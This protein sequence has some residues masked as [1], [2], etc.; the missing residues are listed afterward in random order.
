MKRI[1]PFWAAT[2]VLLL[3]VGL[4]LAAVWRACHGH[5]AY[6]LDD[7]YIHLSIARNLLEDG[8]WGVSR[9]EYVPA[10]SSPLYV[11]LLACTGAWEFSPLLWNLAAG[12]AILRLG[13]RLL[14]EQ[15]LSYRWRLGLLLFVVFAAPLPPMICLG[16]EA[17]VQA[18]ITLAF[19]SA[20]GKEIAA[21][22]PL[23]SRFSLVLLAVLMC[24]IRYEGAFVVGIACLLL[25]L[26]LE[27]RKG[28]WGRA[29]LLGAAGAFPILLY[30]GISLWN[31]HHF[32]PNSIAI[33]GSVPATTSGA[34][35]HWIE[36]AM[37]RFYTSPFLLHTLLALFFVAWF[38]LRQ[39]KTCW[40]LS[41]TACMLIGCSL[42]VHILLSDVALYRYETY[43]LIAGILYAGA[44]IAPQVQD[45]WQ[46]TVAGRGVLLC[47]AGVLLLPFA[48]RTTFFTL[49]YPAGAR[50]IYEQQVQM[51]RFLRQYYPYASVA[52]N[53]IGA[54]TYF[55]HIRL[56]DMIGIGSTPIAE[57]AIAHGSIQVDVGVVR[58]QA[59]ARKVQI[60]L[61]YDNWVGDWVPSEW[62]RVGT[63]T[64]QDNFICAGET[65]S[66]YAVRPEEE[67][68]LRAHLAAFAPILPPGVVVKVE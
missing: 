45:F 2:C 64:I 57:N 20:I 50:N 42:V 22:K 37:D 65:V 29:I 51:G 15:G 5:L 19:V 24:S 25:I 12:I 55:T 59:A 26:P 11:L 54:I 38:G 68:A 60:A 33:K 34:V 67:A 43:L 49:K 18:A 48:V 56:L 9:G 36:Q 52:A 17:T 8:I 1:S 6:T 7:T 21:G 41:T 62:K 39:R 46:T 10:A 14:Q 23:G 13:D 28:R 53:D 30:G 58:A 47:F 3:A 61:V 63:W 40:N 35:G 44:G 31:G 27:N 16:M 32:L 66:F 4:L